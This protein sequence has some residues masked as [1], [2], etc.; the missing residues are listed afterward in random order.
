MEELQCDKDTAFESFTIKLQQ[1][2]N[3][4]VDMYGDI[5]QAGNSQL[6]VLE[7]GTPIPF[8]YLLDEDTMKKSRAMFRVN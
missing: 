4:E 3:N 5:R 7:F 6:K 2:Y 1:H 8:E